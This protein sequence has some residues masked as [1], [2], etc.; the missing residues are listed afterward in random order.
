M[1][2]VGLEPTELT[3]YLLENCFVFELEFSFDFLMVIGIES[4]EF[5]PVPFL[6]EWTTISLLP[7][8]VDLTYLVW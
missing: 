8:S 4:E 2:R 6:A 7:F 1:E 3:Y 5:N